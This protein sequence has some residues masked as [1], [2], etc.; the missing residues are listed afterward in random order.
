ML[1]IEES[2]SPCNCSAFVVKKEIWEIENTD[3]SEN[4]NEVIQWMHSPQTRLT[5]ISLLPKR[6]HITI[7]HLKDYFFSIPLQENDKENLHSQ[8]LL[9]ITLSLQGDIRGPSPHRE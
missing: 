1:S 7:I 9:T 4:H 8:C 2:T 6:R 5:L 3:I